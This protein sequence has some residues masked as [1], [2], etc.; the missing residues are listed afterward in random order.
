MGNY[1]RY[2]VA[3][4]TYFFTVVSYQRKPM[5]ATELARECLRR[6]IE[7]VR[8]RHPFETPAIVLLPDHLHAIW[9]LPAGDA[10]YPM[11]WRRIKEEFSREYLAAGGYEGPR[12]MSRQKRQERAFWQRRY[13][14]HQIDDENDFERHFDYIYYNPVKHGLVDSP[15]D[16]PYSSF[17]RWVE[18]GVYPAGWGR[19]SLGIMRFDDLDE[20]AME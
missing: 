12:S 15:A 10:K 20:T 2:I 4:G 17:H 7:T 5:L 11:R 16:W 18:Q 14:E 1:R 8:E 6:A 19:Q 13:W 9:T 3:G